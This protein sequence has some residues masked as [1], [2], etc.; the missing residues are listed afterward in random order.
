[1]QSSSSLTQRKKI[2]A[3]KIETD[4][5][6]IMSIST[7]SGEH[8]DSSSS[9]E[10]SDSDSSSSY[11]SCD[12]K[13]SDSG[14]DSGYDS[15][16]ECSNT[17][18][19]SLLPRSP[20]LLVRN[21]NTTKWEDGMSIFYKL[22]YQYKQFTSFI[23]MINIFILF[24]NT[25]VRVYFTEQE[26]MAFWII[27]PFCISSIIYTIQQIYM[28]N[29]KP[30]I[31][32]KKLSPYPSPLY[33]Y[34]VLVQRNGD[35]NCSNTYEYWVVYDSTINKHEQII[36]HNMNYDFPTRGPHSC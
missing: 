17:T 18:N 9:S 20:P 15:S 31:S 19:P 25:C 10:Y 8:S 28:L 16:D 29:I 22:H 21:I 12:A 36:V 30:M 32:E 13:Y 4:T 11:D 6:A 24:Y 7:P 2:T 3:L 33:A 34:G 5:D 14:Y 35:I 27:I 26:L 1:M 23:Y